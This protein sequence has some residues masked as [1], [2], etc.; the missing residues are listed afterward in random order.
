MRFLTIL[1]FIGFCACGQQS[2]VK[3]VTINPKAKKLNDS[4][5][6][7]AMQDQNYEK[8]ISLLNQA[9]EVD[10]N[11]ATAYSNKISFG[12]ELKHYDQALNAALKLQEIRPGNP[13]YYF[14]AGI[15]YELKKDSIASKKQFTK[16]ARLYDKILDTMYSG[17]KQLNMLLMNKAITLI[18][19]GSKERGNE[20]LTELYDKQKDKTLSRN[21]GY[22]Y[23]QTQAR[24]Y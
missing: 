12:L 23:E 11:Y 1:L 5:M 18:F 13:D 9:T 10:S 20:I 3:K 6:L 16:A 17:N 19:L 15:I 7:I 21:V 24:H 2:S 4:A 14:T 8:A 22:L